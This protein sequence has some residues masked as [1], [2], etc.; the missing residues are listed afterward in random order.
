MKTE[1]WEQISAFFRKNIWLLFA[2]CAG[3]ALLMFPSS[4][5]ADGDRDDKIT[6]P[7]EDRLTE[8]LRRM[9]GVGDV[10]VLLAEKGGR[11]GGF[12]GAVILCSGS[13]DPAVRLRITEA[14]SAYTGLGS[15]QI[16]VEKIEFA[17][18]IK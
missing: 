11:E 17:G 8:T 5:G 16:I 12:S 9:K 13:E 10:Y 18:G 1:R 4:S 3:V 2:L 15:H 14:V 7:E 6:S